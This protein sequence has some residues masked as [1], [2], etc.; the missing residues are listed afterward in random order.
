MRLKKITFL[1]LLCFFAFLFSISTYSN[2]NHNKG[3]LS[4]TLQ[5]QQ[6]FIHYLFDSDNSDNYNASNVSALANANSI[7]LTKNMFVAGAVCQDITVQLDATGNVTIAEDD[8]N[9]GSTG[10]GPLTFD[11]DITSFTCAD[12]GTNSVTLTVTDTSVKSSLICR[13]YIVGL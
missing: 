3:Y 8:V 9:N 13:K 11:T 7:L 6:V 4:P 10:G 1:K 2:I 12:I 5:F